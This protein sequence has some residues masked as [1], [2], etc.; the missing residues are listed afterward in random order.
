MP[1]SI[2]KSAYFKSSKHISNHIEYI[3]RQSKIFGLDGDMEVEAAVADVDAHPHSQFWRQIYSLTAEDTARLSL[4]RDY[5]KTLIVSKRDEIAKNYNISPENLRIIASFHPK[6]NNPHLHMVMYS[7]NKREGHLHVHNKADRSKIMNRAS[8]GLKSVFTNTIFKFD[9]D[10]IKIAKDQQR[11]LLN[12][13]IEK[14][15]LQ[16]NRSGYFIDPSVTIRLRELGAAISQQ[17]GRKVYGYMPP[18]VKEEID[19]ILQTIVQKDATAA[20]YFEMYG[21]SQLALT[22]TYASAS[23]TLGRKMSEWQQKFFHPQKGDDTTRHNA[24]IRAALQLETMSNPEKLEQR[25]ATEFVEKTPANVT[26]NLVHGITK[27]LAGG[28]RMNDAKQNA[29]PSK[30]NQHD[31]HHDRTHNT[32]MD[33]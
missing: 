28:A 16:I 10:D 27:A 18:A 13:T 30:R 23:E 33:R 21:K 17:P 26:Q 5:Y 7:T 15:L 1:K 4:D 25:P 29:K 12:Q 2:I 32:G 14:D 24:I 8:V 20:K 6:A 31:R 9:L 19:G 22:E 3:D 11:H